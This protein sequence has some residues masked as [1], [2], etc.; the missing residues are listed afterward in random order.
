MTFTEQAKALKDS[1]KITL[2]ELA[3]A[4]HISESTASRYLSGALTPTP[5]M[6]AKI[7]AFLGD[8]GAGGPP[9]DP[10]EGPAGQE[11]LLLGR[12]L[13]MI[14]FFLQRSHADQVRQL[15]DALQHERREKYF[16]IGLLVALLAVVFFILIYD[17]TH[18]SVGWIR[19]SMSA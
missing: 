4:C 16:F 2:R 6:A 13:Q 12:N 8:A 11:D 17:Y 10:Q 9:G 15:S 14:S 18:T 1:Q 5:E 3:D 19:A 7:L